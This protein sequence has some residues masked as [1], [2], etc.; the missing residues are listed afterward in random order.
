MI[1]TL[2]LNKLFFCFRDA[3]CPCLTPK[4]KEGH[5]KKE[6]EQNLLLQY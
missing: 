6:E 1:L 5:A 4:D 2:A 3:F